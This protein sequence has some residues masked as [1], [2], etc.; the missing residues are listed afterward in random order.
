MVH[1]RPPQVR[2]VTLGDRVL[3]WSDRTGRGLWDSE[4]ARA[5]L[6]TGAG[7]GPLLARLAALGMIDGGAPL[8]DRVAVRNAHALLLPASQE[9]WCANPL[10]PTSG[11]FDWQALELEPPEVLLWRAFNGTRTLR[12]AAE[13]AGVGTDT[14]LA[15]AGRLTRLEVQALQLREHPARPDDIARRRLFSPPRPPGPRLEHQL[16]TRGG[17]VLARWH[18]E[19]IKTPGTHFDLV[20]TTL[21][22][23]FEHPHAAL[24]GQGFGA[25]L[26]DRLALSG[27]VGE[28]GLLVEVGPGTGAL[29]AAWLARAEETNRTP[30]RYLRIDAAP[31]LLAMQAIRAPGTEGVR[32]LADALP[33]EDASVDFLLSNEVIADLRA[34]PEDAM[35]RALRTRHGLSAL[36][37]GA[38]YNVGT[39]RFIE[40]IARVLRPGG[41][42]YIS[43]FGDLDEVPRE[44]IHLD[45]PEV[46]IHFGHA[47]R[48]ARSCGLAADVVRLDLLLGADLHASWLSRP[49]T[50]ALR[51]L[52][53]RHGEHLEARA[54]TCSTAPRPVPL[55]GL[56]EVP[57]TRDGPGPVITRFHALL[58]RKGGASQARSGKTPRT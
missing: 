44:T 38:R 9:L 53:A 56:E 32:G 26:L 28:G 40:E 24:H 47:L 1:T 48:V 8:L 3:L 51:A 43:E 33:L 50:L 11:G 21:A 23:A 12:Q 5:A 42:A 16:D 30:S 25:R 31:A 57:I 14:A 35:V 18:E 49:S 7:P 27:S 19:E 22:H 4:G 10:C 13:R 2:T 58:L 36:P 41:R 29:A 37:D 34:A 6:E 39:W 20:E 46:S 52:C 45:H 15:L 55:E 17:T 54:W